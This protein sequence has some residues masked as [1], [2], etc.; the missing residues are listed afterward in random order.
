MRLLRL[1]LALLLAAAPAFAGSDPASSGAVTEIRLGTAPA[2]PAPPDPARLRAVERFLAARQAA[3]AARA[4]GGSAR[5]TSPTPKGASAEDLYG[6]RDRRLVAFDFYDAALDPVGAG[7]FEA[8]VY[9]LF[10]DA[11]GQVVESRHERLVFAGG[12]GGWSC[13]KLLLETSIEWDSATI[14]EAAASQ[15]L[16]EEFAKARA[17]LASWSSG[18]RALAYSVADVTKSPDGRVVVSCLRFA[19]DSGRRGFDVRQEP[20]VLS[21]DRAGVRVESH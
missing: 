11:T 16:S 9:L 2:A 6:T 1:P 20:V 15:G 13:V 4:S 21:R 5:M 3:S 12:S 10:A 19:A 7:R 17:H 14:Q 8:T 18:D